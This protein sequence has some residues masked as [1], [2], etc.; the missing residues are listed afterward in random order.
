MVVTVVSLERRDGWVE[1]DTVV[2][3][4]LAL[5]S[6]IEGQLRRRLRQ[7]L[8]RALIFRALDAARGG[9]DVVRE[10]VVSAGWA[11]L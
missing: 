1:H 9:V 8:Q 3:L 5:C 11:E 6:V 2:K 4:P 7:V 10:S